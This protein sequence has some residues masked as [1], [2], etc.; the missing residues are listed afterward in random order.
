MNTET[1]I[2]A[3]REIPRV[4]YRT[5]QLPKLKEKAPAIEVVRK[6]YEYGVRF[7][8]TADFYGNGFA[9][10]CL[11]E[12]LKDKKDA[13]IVTKI[14]AKPTKRGPMPMLPAQRPEELRQHVMD[15][16]KSLHVDCLDVVILRRIAP[17]TFPL[18]PK[19]KVKFEDQMKE[20]VKMR[21]EGLIK[22]IGLS[23]VSKKELEYAL[24]YGMVCVQNQYNLKSRKQEPILKMC[25]E[26][27]IAWMPYSPLGGGLPGSTKVT[28]DETVQN[29]ARDLKLSPVQVSL[30]WLLQHS[31]NTLLI[32]GTTNVSHLREN[33]DVAKIKLPETVMQKLDSVPPAKGIGGIINGL[34][35]L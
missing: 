28:E 17:G 24:P 23:C 1:F 32:L 8:D 35:N 20:M 34:L 25:E 15:N 7:Y 3:D 10:N 11:S 4:G 18:T 21:E 16:L 6:A 33:I 30:A 13:V 5:M 2:F 14:G 29:V 26:N 12:T 22:Y 27:N 19:Q 9:N 31:K